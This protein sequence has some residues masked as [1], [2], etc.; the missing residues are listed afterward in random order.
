M[1]EGPT[2][3]WPNLILRMDEGLAAHW[4]NLILQGQIGTMG[5]LH[6]G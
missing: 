3:H 2:A 1:D 6:T 4:V 5:Q